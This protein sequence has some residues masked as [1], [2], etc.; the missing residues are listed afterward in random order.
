MKESITEQEVEIT[1]AKKEV[2]K[3]IIE[4]KVAE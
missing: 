1:T 3:T 4:A 2:E